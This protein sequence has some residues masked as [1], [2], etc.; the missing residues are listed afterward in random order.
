MFGLG[1]M[2]SLPTLYLPH[3]LLAGVRSK[4][5]ELAAGVLEC[6]LCIRMLH[7]RLVLGPNG[8]VVY[9][10][11]DLSPEIGNPVLDPGLQVPTSNGH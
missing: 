8:I 7:R 10:A 2:Y 9:I 6:S 5:F 4:L 3:G 11:V 1:A